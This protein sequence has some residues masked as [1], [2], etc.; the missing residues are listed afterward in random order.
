MVVPL[1]NQERSRF[2]KGK[3]PHHSHLTN[4]IEYT[5]KDNSCGPG[6]SGA[7]PAAE[8]VQQFDDQSSEQSAM[9][10][11]CHLISSNNSDGF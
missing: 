4:Q 8:L 2:Q 11:K 3:L 5:R 1:R 6:Q 9:E 7:F 10:K